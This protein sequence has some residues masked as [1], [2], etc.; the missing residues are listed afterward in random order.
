MAQS[1]NNI[2]LCQIYLSLLKNNDFILLKP[3]LTYQNKKCHITDIK[4][5]KA[6]TEIKKTATLKSVIK[7]FKSPL[8]LSFFWT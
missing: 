3:E 4:N 1:G 6:I 8:K 5:P 7:F 2:N